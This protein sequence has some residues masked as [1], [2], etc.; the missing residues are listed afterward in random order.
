MNPALDWNIGESERAARRSRLRATRAFMCLICLTVN[1]WDGSAHAQNDYEITNRNWNGLSDFVQVFH[2]NGTELLAPRELALSELRPTDAILLFFPGTDLDPNELSVFLSSGGRVVVLDD[3]GASSSLLREF[4]IERRA[5]DPRN[6]PRLRGNPELLLAHRG[7]DHPLTRDVDNII[8][9]HPQSVFHPGLSP[10]FQFGDGPGQALVLVGAVGQGKLVIVSDPSVLINNMLVFPGNRRFASN[11]ANYLATEGAGR[12]FIATPTTSI[13]GHVGDRPSSAPGT[14]RDTLNQLAHASL[15]PALVQM[16][17]IG[18]VLILL[19]FAATALPRR[20]PY[21]SF[22]VLRRPAQGGGRWNEYKTYQRGVDLHTLLVSYLD[23]FEASVGSSMG[24]PPG[25]PLPF[26]SEAL[27]A[28][29]MEP[30]KIQSFTASLQRLRHLRDLQERQV[31]PLEI[32][33]EEL[34]RHVETCEQLRS[35]VGSTTRPAPV[36]L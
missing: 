2:D 5:V 24:V 17:T 35:A 32:S 31:A 9:N 23:A 1:G 4:G 15:P 13:V 3:F 20:S 27:R 18:L 30:S 21:E 7:K 29:R 26:W 11:L 14:L 36:L 12:I 25:A 16:G 33:R 34:Q 6:V 28:R 8:S 10:L 22:V 19:V